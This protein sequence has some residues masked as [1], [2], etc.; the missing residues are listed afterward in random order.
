M[1]M[2]TTKNNRSD[3]IIAGNIIIKRMKRHREF[4]KGNKQ[5]NKLYLKHY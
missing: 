1:K 4:K 2:K 5:N 3:I